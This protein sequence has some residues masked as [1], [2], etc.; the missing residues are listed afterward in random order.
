MNKVVFQAGA[1]A[2]ALLF[3]SPAK[4]QLAPTTSRPAATTPIGGLVVIGTS[5]TLLIPAYASTGQA[6][7]IRYQFQGTGFACIS[8]VSASPVITGTTSAATCSPGAFLVTANSVDNRLTGLAP[9][10][11]TALWG[12][13]AAGS[14]LQITY[15]ID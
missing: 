13:A 12:M 4:A 7:G 9:L 2:L 8:F 6:W 5:A 1:G 14:T 11:K 10:P 15:E 3:A